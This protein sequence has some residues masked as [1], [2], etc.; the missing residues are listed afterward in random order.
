MTMTIDRQPQAANGNGGEI[1][2]RD[3]ARAVR[4]SALASMAERFSIDPSRLMEVMKATVIKGTA[5]H[6]PSDEEVAVFIVVANQY[7]LNPFTREIHAFCDGQRGVVPIVGIDGWSHIVNAE[8]RF[9]GC[10]FQ[11]VKG[12]D[13]DLGMTC[14]M[15]V[16]G[17]SH[18]IPVT[19]WLSECKRNTPPWNGMKRR[20]LRH[21]AFMQCAR[22][23]FSISGIYD[24]D[25]ARDIINGE[26]VPNPQPNGGVKKLLSKITNKEVSEGQTF[27]ASPEALESARLAEE[28]ALRVIAE[29]SPSAQQQSSQQPPADLPSENQSIEDGTEGQQ[30]PAPATA[31]EVDT[32][33]LFM[34][35]INAAGIDHFDKPE[36]LQK[37]LDGRLMRIQKKGKLPQTTVQWRLD[38]LNLLRSGKLD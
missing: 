14:T 37:W 10:D 6:R 26:V 30:A 16:K 17:R 2:A 20:M 1:Q 18:P 29:K 12:E 32:P 22:L 28:E 19:E 9:D 4:K 21:K 24:E 7:G 34:D 11:E 3:P 38:T 15:H 35:A 25:E 36:K 5:N 33:E 31:E 23:A 13:G 8:P 27:E